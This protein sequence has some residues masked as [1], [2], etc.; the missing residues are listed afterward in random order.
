MV[1][2]QYVMVFSFPHHMESFPHKSE[3]Q[4][5]STPPKKQKILGLFFSLSLLY[6]NT[7]QWIINLNSKEQ[8]ESENGT[9]NHVATAK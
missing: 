8:Q 9:K 2:V 6:G 5:L 4:G 1:K 7:V 3:I